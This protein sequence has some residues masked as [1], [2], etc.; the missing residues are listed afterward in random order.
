MGES[1]RLVSGSIFPNGALKTPVHLRKA[2]EGE[3]VACSARCL[4]PPLISPK[5]LQYKCPTFLTGLPPPHQR[6]R[7][8]VCSSSFPE[9]VEV[10]ERTTTQHQI[11]LRGLDKF[12]NYSVQV[13][14]ST[15]VG[16]GLRSRSI[17]CTT[18]EDGKSNNTQ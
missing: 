4:P 17:Y 5:G 11:T 3:A 2:V 6:K 1:P 12:Q 15:R 16:Q 18:M 7:K 8:R 14:A 13:V 9:K 10:V